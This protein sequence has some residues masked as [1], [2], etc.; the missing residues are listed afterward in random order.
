M[1]VCDS[2]QNG[3]QNIN[4]HSLPNNSSGKY[5]SNETQVNQDTLVLNN[6]VIVSENKGG[7]EN[8]YIKEKMLGEGSFGQ[9]WLVR[10][11]TFGTQFA[12]K[13]IEKG[14]N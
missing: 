9:V 4:N 8:H 13:I 1:G 7:I 5:F 3:A 2:S 12:L 11:K 14:P 6:E 10:H